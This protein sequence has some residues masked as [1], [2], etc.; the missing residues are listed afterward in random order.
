MGSLSAQL[1]TEGAELL[2]QTLP[3]WQRGELTPEPQEETQATYSRLIGKEAGELDWQLS[4]QELSR[5][6]RAFQPWPG[7]YTWWR[8]RR[9]KVLEATP[10]S[11][12]GAEPGRVVALG[13]GSPPL[14]VVTGDGSLGLLKLQ[15]EGKRPMAA[16]EFLRGHPD[17][18]GSRLGHPH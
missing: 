1:A 16:E 2:T 5:R 4:A 3:R 11:A 9:L 17:L 15:L 12:R 8:Q 10:V 13:P 14:G 7:S 6:I 18:E